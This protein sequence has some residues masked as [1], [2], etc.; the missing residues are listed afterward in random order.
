MNTGTSP[1]SNM[2]SGF[3]SVAVGSEGRT[4]RYAALLTGT[5]P[6]WFN[7][8]HYLPAFICSVPY[9]RQLFQATPQP[10]SFILQ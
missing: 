9:L 6:A 2:P 1:D 7:G 10:Q 5:L 3:P 4:Q 8:L